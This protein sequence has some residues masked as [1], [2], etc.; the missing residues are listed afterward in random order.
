VHRE[1]EYLNDL[2]EERIQ[3]R[4]E[5][6]SDSSSIYST[7]KRSNTSSSSSS[8]SSSA[9]NSNSRPTSPV[10]GKGVKSNKRTYKK[11]IS[12]IIGSGTLKKQTQYIQLNKF[13]INIDA[14]K[15]E[16]KLILKYVSTRNTHN[17][18]KR[19]SVSNAIR[20]ILIQLAETSEFN[21][22]LYNK[23]RADEKLFMIDFLNKTHIDVGLNISTPDEKEKVYNVLL[24][25]Y[26]SGNNNPQLI[27]QLKQLIHDGVERGEIPFHQG[28]QI[29]TEIN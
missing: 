1:T 28:L 25:Q 12:F 8:S 17:S 16:N 14:L 29:L 26:R 9:T 5:N 15:S 23:L 22:P 11:P 19:Q 27:K 13:M 10:T 18:I 20:D 2:T 24:G 6:T 4:N 3:K 7:P 21:K